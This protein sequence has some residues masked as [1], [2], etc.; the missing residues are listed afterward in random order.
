MT[1]RISCFLAVFVLCLSCQDLQSQTL[2]AEAEPNGTS[3]TATP[4][5]L[6]N[7]V[8]K[9]RGNVYP[10]ADEDFYSFSVTGAARVF[11][12]TQTSFSS[13]AVFDTLL[14]IRDTN[15]TT[16]L[17]SDNDDGSFG[18]TSS[19]IAGCQL[20]V[21]GTYFIRVIHNTAGQIRGY[22]LYVSVETGTPTAEVEPNDA[23]ATATPVPADGYISGAAN[24]AANF[25][26]FSLN[27]NQGDTIAVILNCD[28]E[29]DAVTFNGR[30]GVAL[31]G[32]GLNQI[33]VANDTNTTSPNAE[34][35]FMTV[36]ITGTYL[37]FAD[38]G[39]AG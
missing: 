2:Q 7:G 1:L 19:V 34:A 22:D 37:V 36:A 14:E 21:A 31:F 33:L 39:G 3:A 6:T 13:N 24:P 26:F 25:D 12:A 5:T 35:I 10:A 23:P 9:V 28:P 30:C 15:G 32:D 20:P 29:R 8:A 16:V 38:D 4:L 18:T 27:L 17:E 11:A